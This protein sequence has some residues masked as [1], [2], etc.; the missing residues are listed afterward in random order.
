LVRPLSGKALAVLNRLPRL[1]DHVFT[2]GGKAPIGGVSVLKRGLDEA[3]GVVGWTIHDLRR[4]ARSLMSRAEVPRDYA[5]RCLGH[6][7]RGVEGT[8]DRHKYRDQML[9]AY[10]KLAA[11]IERIVAPPADNVV[12][13]RGE[14]PA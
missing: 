13:L 7:I 9:R 6:V 5:E 11:L 4:T 1:G 3:S 8:Y 10:E 2:I 12:L 14:L